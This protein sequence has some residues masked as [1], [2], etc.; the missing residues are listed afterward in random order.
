MVLSTL[1]SS[2]TFGGRRGAPLLPCHASY[3]RA[4]GPSQTARNPTVGEVPVRAAPTGRLAA[5][6]STC[7]DVAPSSP[8][9]GSCDTDETEYNLEME[10]AFQVLDADG[11]GMLSMMVT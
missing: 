11:D 7:S 9:N 8:P 3:C 10:L 4:L 1:R 5:G 2:R 6:I